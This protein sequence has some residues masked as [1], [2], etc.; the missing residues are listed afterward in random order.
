MIIKSF[1]KG[2]FNNFILL[3]LYFCIR[4]AYKIE[5]WR[6]DV[7]IIKFNCFMHHSVSKGGHHKTISS[8]STVKHLH[9]PERFIV[10]KFTPCHLSRAFGVCLMCVMWIFI[11]DSLLKFH[12]KSKCGM[13][14]I[15]KHKIDLLVVVSIKNCNKFQVKSVST[16][17]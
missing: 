14:I 4:N 12:L 1:F 6:T 2:I 15:L 11:C 9:S 16:Y 17:Y 13:H 3:F 5:Y 10:N 8:H 7:G